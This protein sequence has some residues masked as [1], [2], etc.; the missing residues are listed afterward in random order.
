MKP[1]FPAVVYTKPICCK[2]AAANST[3]AGGGT[4]AQG[5]GDTRATDRG[6]PQR[7]QYESGGADEK[8]HAVES[9][10]THVVHPH[11]LGRRT[12]GPR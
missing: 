6:E 9:K 4:G 7:D 3:A 12:R 8:T 11:S 1:A 5:S 2:L 10:R